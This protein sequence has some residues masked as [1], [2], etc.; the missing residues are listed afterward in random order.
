VANRV[1][2]TVGRYEILRELGRGGAATV[3][4]ARQTDLDR[5]VALKELSSFRQSDPSFTKRFLRESRL[6]GSLSHPNIVTVHEYFEHGGIPY[7]A[8]EYVP[9]GSLRPHIGH[10]SLTQVAGVLEGILSALDHAERHGIVH[11]DMKPENVMV[12]SEGRVKIADFGIAKA[13]GK[14]Q[15]ASFM[16]ATGMTVGTPNYIAPEQAMGRE[17]GPWTDLYSVGVMAFEFF[18]G[19]VPFYDTEEPIA[20]LMRQVSDPIPPVRS[21]NPEIDEATSDWIGHLVAKDPAER[22]QSAE[23]AWDGFEEI[24]L[25]LV[26]PRW[27]RSAALLEPSRRS[28]ETPAGPATPP[29]TPA[30]RPPLMPTHETPNWAPTGQPTTQPF[31]PPSRSTMSKAPTRRLEEDAALAE[32]VMPDAPT[33]RLDE[34]E[35]KPP[36]D[37]RRRGRFGLVKGAF[38][39]FAVLVAAAAAFG[40]R[41]SQPDRASEGTVAAPTVDVAGRDLALRVPRGWSRLRGSPDLGLP[42]SHASAVGPRGRPGGPRVEFGVMTGRTASNSALLPAGLLGSIGQAPGEVPARTAVRLPT[43]NLEAWRYRNLRAVGADRQLTIYAI[44]TSGGVA[45]LACASRPAQ[46]RAFA[47]GCDAIA[48]TLRLRRGTPYPI[49]PSHAYATSLNGTIGQL[50]QATGPEEQ[51]LQAA[52]TLSGQAAAARALASAYNDAAAQLAALSV[53]PADRAANA[54]LV[55]ALRGAGTAYGRAAR[56]ATG[57]DPDAYRAASAAVPGARAEVNSALAGVRAAGYEPATPQDESAAPRESA[58]RGENAPP[59]ASEPDHASPPESDS[60]VGDSR[61]DDPSDDEEEN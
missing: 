24:V 26:G 32:T 57:G 20:V 29:P 55:T 56:A 30:A 21:I 40:G 50:Q 19:H 35:G 44:P 58:P 52:E 5:L 45:T 13:T 3:Y 31:P 42:L 16:T 48:G 14:A 22:T 17:V 39:L 54:R 15:T 38:L 59:A 37:T 9:R 23:E 1:A 18:V 6:A 2:R 43:Q 28:P 49:G 33:R 8:M 53:S 25:N 11:R 36:P 61:S 60:G 27:R 51:N 10:M 12:T 46:A 7:I 34:G 41:G 47:P 4:L